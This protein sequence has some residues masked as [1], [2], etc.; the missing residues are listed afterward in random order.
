MMPER[1]A[2]SGVA[3]LNDGQLNKGTAFSDEERARLRIE[4]LLPPRVETLPEQGARVVEN[5]RQKTSGLEQYCYLRALQDENETLFYRTLLDHLEELLPIVYTPTVGRACTEWSRIYERPR[6]IYVSA[7]QRGRIAAVLANWP[8]RDVRIIVVTDG[9]RILGLGDLG[10]NGMGIPIGKL[11]L[12]TACGGVPPGLCLPITLDVGTDN[13]A[14]RTDPFYLGIREARL[15]GDAYDAF[16]DEFVSAVQSGF[17]QAV[18]QFEDFNNACA[19]RLLRRY[20]DR[21]CCFNDDIQGTGAMGLA[22]LYAAGRIANL[23]LAQQRILFVGAGE[24]CL[25]IGRIVSE[26]MQHEGL[27][28]SEVQDRLLFMDSKGLVITERTDLPEHKRLFAQNRNAV[29]DLLSAVEAFQPTALI[30]ACGKG[31]MFTQPVL[32]AMARINARPIVF[33]L[34]NPTANS[35]CTAQE[36]YTWTLGR[37]IFASGSPFTSACI[38]EETHAPSQANNAHVFP[39]MGLG[40]LVAGASRAT[41]EMFLAA[42]RELAAQVSAVHRKNGVVFPPAQDMPETAGHIAHA[43]ASIAYER[44]FATRPRPRNLR[45]AIADF[46]YEAR[47]A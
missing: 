4:G 20:R 25:G 36:A 24:A 3:L 34:S 13:E 43:V 16:I 29:P 46:R 6:G 26:A 41:D 38:A 37:A 18:L 31:G 23:S 22:G 5:L 14:L 27:A 47:Y 11:T 30:G 8:H 19:F 21:L 9:A 35:E 12:Y 10:A 17:P 39:G 45:Q 28:Q 42:A 44:G 2:L 15:R 40:L 1:C 7:H 32:Q 33:A